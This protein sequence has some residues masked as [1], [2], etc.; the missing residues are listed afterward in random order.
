MDDRYFSRPLTPARSMES[1]TEPVYSNA[2]IFSCFRNSGFRGVTPDIAYLA[3]SAPRAKRCAPGCGSLRSRKNRNS[4]SNLYWV[5]HFSFLTPYSY[6][7]ISLESLQTAH[8]DAIASLYA[9]MKKKTGNNTVKVSVCGE[10]TG[11][12]THDPFWVSW[13]TA[14]GACGAMAPDCAPKTLQ[15]ADVSERHLANLETGGRQ[16]AGA[17]SYAGGASAQLQICAELVA[18]RGYDRP[19][20]FGS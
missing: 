16:S 20:A 8:N 12:G 5:H 4:R 17:R 9:V 14:P 19:L 1:G 18:R 3:Q 13:E 11:S 10:K 2:I 15:E 6:A 7:D